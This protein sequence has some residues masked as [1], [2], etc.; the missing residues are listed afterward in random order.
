MKNTG[1]STP[2]KDQTL[3]V[4]VGFSDYYR[5]EIIDTV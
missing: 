1:L 2:E 4:K 3:D 5:A